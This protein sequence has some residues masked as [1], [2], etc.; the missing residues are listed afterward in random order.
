M[1][2]IYAALEIGTTRTV[3]AIGEAQSGERLRMTS[4]AEIPSSGIRKS[5]I[6]SI[7]DATQSVRSVLREIER[8]QDSG[9]K[10]TIG[11][12]VLAVSG[13]HILAT[14]A[15]GQA[16]VESGKVGDGDEGE[17]L[18]DE[19]GTGVVRRRRDDGRAEP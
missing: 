10:M 6:L 15:D 19:K 1:S 3:L 12:A 18:L 9:T 4:Y 11:N 17:R 8:R 14:H 13:Q 7:P 2:S 5:Q 16:I